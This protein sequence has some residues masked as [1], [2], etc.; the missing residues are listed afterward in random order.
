M[1]SDKKQ[2]AKQKKKNAG[3]N[4]YTHSYPRRRFAS[5]AELLRFLPEQEYQW[6][7]HF[8][9]NLRCDFS[10]VNFKHLKEYCDNWAFNVVLEL[11]F[12][13]NIMSKYGID[14]LAKY[15]TREYN[16][17]FP[18]RRGIVPEFSGA[19]LTS[20]HTWENAVERLRSILSHNKKLIRLPNLNIEINGIKYQS[21]SD[22]I[23]VQDSVGVGG[24]NPIAVS[25]PNWGK[26]GRIPDRT[27][28]P[29]TPPFYRTDVY[30]PKKSLSNK[31]LDIVKIFKEQYEY[32][33]SEWD[34]KYVSGYELFTDIFKKGEL[35][36]PYFINRKLPLPLILEGL[37]DSFILICRPTDKVKFL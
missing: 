19:S 28:F 15:I 5:V 17:V 35:E 12:N 29:D 24:Q 16:K 22:Y 2:Q 11:S 21:E 36:A 14:C 9:K 32:Q 37:R 7:F 27:E 6:Y 23:Y 26:C 8:P 25:Y 10:K 1:K 30:F 13:E 31:D 34:G 4:I 20:I 33:I 18:I 3:D